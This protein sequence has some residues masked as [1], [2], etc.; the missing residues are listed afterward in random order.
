MKLNIQD[1]AAK[2]ECEK[3]E[4]N[5]KAKAINKDSIQ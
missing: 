1:C 2:E 4:C 5:Y 3:K